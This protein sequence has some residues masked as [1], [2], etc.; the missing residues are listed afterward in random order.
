MQTLLPGEQPEH[1]APNGMSE[2]V[3]PE[4][5]DVCRVDA[6]G[7]GNVRA[8]PPISPGQTPHSDQ[9]RTV[10]R[11]HFNNLEMRR[12]FTVPPP[13][14]VPDLTQFYE[15]VLQILRDLANAV[16]REARRNDVVQLELIGENIQNHVSVTINNDDD[17]TV[18]PAFEGLLEWLVQSKIAS[19]R[20]H[21]MLG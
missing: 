3:D 9:Y 7:R 11:D 16:R 4:H 6:A 15:D 21:R 8:E 10:S 20:L 12:M 17:D 19:P 1:Q 14:N 5:P 18:F 2:G 13:R